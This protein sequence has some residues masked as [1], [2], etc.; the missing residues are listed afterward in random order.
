M[1]GHGHMGRS[2]FRG[3]NFHIVCH[4]DTRYD[5]DDASEIRDQLTSWG[6]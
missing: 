5:I 3:W 2:S 6:W 4:K 1:D